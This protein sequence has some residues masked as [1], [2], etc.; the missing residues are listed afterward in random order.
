MKE[1][2]KYITETIG[3]EIDIKVLPQKKHGML[4][5]FLSE[6][7]QLSEVR[8]FNHI[9]ILAE[10]RNS[11][12]LSI[13]QTEKHFKIIN[14]TLNFKVVLL[15]KN[16]PSFNRKRLIG[17]GIN[18]IVPGK[19]LFLPTIL[20]D[21]NETITQNRKMGKKETLLPSAQ[22]IILYRIL[23]KNKSQ[24]IG[25]LSFKQ[26]AGILHYTPM[27]ITNAV[28]NLKYHEICTTVG[29]KEKYIRFNLEIP[30]MWNDLEKRNL[31]V[32][33]VLKKIF[34]DEKPGG[35]KMVRS[36]FSAL[37]DYS[38]MNPGNQEFYALDKTVFYSLK[39]NN[40]LVNA[41]EYEG[42]YCL[43]VWKYNPETLAGELPKDAPVV[44]PVSLYL[45]LKDSHDERIEMALEQIMEKYLTAQTD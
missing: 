24:N 30:E 3:A 16:L 10:R 18:F 4:P 17:K 38:D 1:L 20:I 31:L 6:I 34:T 22:V 12:E 11:D 41:N 5:M 36:N 13:L 27:V 43:E 26:L 28:N 44:D 33:P 35:V 19:Q 42:R 32:N 39:K 45:S 2:K 40:A 9:F 25:E 14:E 8:M 29:E 23:Q 7:Y 37:P 21:L 15:A